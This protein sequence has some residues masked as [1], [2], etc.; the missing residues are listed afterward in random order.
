MKYTV[1]A[2]AMRSAS[3]K[4]RCFYCHQSIGDEHKNDCILL[5]KKHIIQVQIEL[6]MDMP[7]S[8]D[9]ESIEFFLNE[10]SWCSDNITIYIEKVMET[11][12]LCGITTCTELS[13]T[14]DTYLEES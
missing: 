7:A 1:T 8:W 12:C 9:K 2:F 11:G 14:S 3:T 5:K 4:N 6:E 10:G 13:S